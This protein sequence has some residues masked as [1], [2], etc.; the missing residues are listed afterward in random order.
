MLICSAMVE[1]FENE[2]VITLSTKQ[3]KYPA[4][5]QTSISI[6][7]VK[8]NIYLRFILLHFIH[9]LY[10]TRWSRW[11]GTQ[12]LWTPHY[13]MV[14]SCSSRLLAAE[15]DQQPLAGVALFPHRISLEATRIKIP[16]Q[17][18]CH[19]CEGHAR[20]FAAGISPAALL[21]SVG[22]RPHRGFWCPETGPGAPMSATPAPPVPSPSEKGTSSACS[23]SLGTALDSS[24]PSCLYLVLVLNNV[25][26]GI[27]LSLL[28]HE[29]WQQ[30]LLHN[31]HR[32]LLVLSQEGQPTPYDTHL[33]THLSEGKLCIPMRAN[34]CCSV[35][36]DLELSS[37]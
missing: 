8:L 12:S 2:K 17:K 31:A 37:H 23:H 5:F 35:I 10:S 11:R 36:L 30:H 33:C 16:H 28:L 29:G 13:L 25:C 24:F 34:P 15:N 32:Y 3:I 22:Y 18:Q 14:L 4:Y 21:D 7:N 9:G 27:G 19:A 26:A 20:P 6:I 1:C